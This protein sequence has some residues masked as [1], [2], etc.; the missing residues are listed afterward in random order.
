MMERMAS[1][2]AG[3]FQGGSVLGRGRAVSKAAISQPPQLLPLPP[4]A[5][6]HSRA[7][8]LQ[9]LHCFSRHPSCGKELVGK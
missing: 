8:H 4:G 9:K 6:G 3:G 5:S 2:V 1:E 7:F